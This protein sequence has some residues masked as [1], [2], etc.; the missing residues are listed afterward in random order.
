M[1]WCEGSAEGSIV[2]G[3]NG[4]GKE[5]EG[6]IES[7]DVCENRP[8]SMTIHS[9]SHSPKIVLM[10]NA[11]CNTRCVHLCHTQ[12]LTQMPLIYTQCS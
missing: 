6:G 12:T 11:F 9:H 2:L 4:Q 5:C 8:T 1:C 7:V 3:G 10:L